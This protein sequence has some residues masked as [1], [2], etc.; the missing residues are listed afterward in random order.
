M[1]KNIDPLLTGRLLKHLDQLGHGDVFGLVD[2]NF[3]AYRY[4]RPVI[5]LRAATTETAAAA[6]LSVFPLDSYVDH[7]IRRMEIDDQ[8]DVINEA[9][10]ALQRAADAA[11]GTTVSIQGVER[12][13]FY[14]QAAEARF[15]VQ[16][17]ETIPYACYLLKKGVV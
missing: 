9:A 15:L 12:F 2:R 13:E 7:P 14:R 1:L 3:P 4:D 8:P 17:G 6:L 10:A 5:D 11:E 16:T